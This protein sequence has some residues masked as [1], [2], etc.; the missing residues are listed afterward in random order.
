M[1][2]IPPNVKRF[3]MLMA[4]LTGTLEASGLPQHL[5]QFLIGANRFTGSVNFTAFPGDLQVI[6][7]YSNKFI[8]ASCAE[9]LLVIIT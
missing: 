4:D 5:K 7:L 8:F 9:T 2:Y 6:S 1:E 3:E